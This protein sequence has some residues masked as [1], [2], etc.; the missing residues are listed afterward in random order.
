MNDTNALGFFFPIAQNLMNFLLFV[1]YNN[2]LYIDHPLL[3]CNC[4]LSLFIFQSLRE[5]RR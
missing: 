2:L 1:F 5:M 3:Q 4:F